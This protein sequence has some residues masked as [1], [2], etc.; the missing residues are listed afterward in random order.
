MYGPKKSVPM[1]SFVKLLSHD[2]ENGPTLW[3]V[4]LNPSTVYTHNVP[5]AKKV[6]GLL[7]FEEHLPQI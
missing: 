6:H 4:F 1:G 7:I 2:M 5:S 3:K